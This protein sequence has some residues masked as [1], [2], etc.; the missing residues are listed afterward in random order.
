MEHN[1][2]H[3]RSE[4]KYGYEENTTVKK[5]SYKEVHK[6]LERYGEV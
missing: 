3:T 1:G 4:C 6:S 5:L 2:Q